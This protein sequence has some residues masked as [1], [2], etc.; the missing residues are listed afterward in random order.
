MPRCYK[1][2]LEGVS[3][4]FGGLIQVNIF[5]RLGKIFLGWV[6]GVLLTVSIRI[7]AY[8]VALSC[9]VT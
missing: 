8:C 4:D 9:K 1:C 3:Y 5:Q 2:F 6:L 7:V